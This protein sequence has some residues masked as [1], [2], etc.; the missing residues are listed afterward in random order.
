MA[1]AAAAYTHLWTPA[2]TPAA[3][4]SPATNAIGRESESFMV[5]GWGLE[6]M[7]GIKRERAG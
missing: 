2:S 6:R 5:D 3:A 1:A 7:V 4:A